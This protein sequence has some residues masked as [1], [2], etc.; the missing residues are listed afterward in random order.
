MEAGRGHPAL[1]ITVDPASKFN[2][3]EK[4]SLAAV[5]EDPPDPPEPAPEGAEPTLE[6]T[7]GAHGPTVCSAIELHAAPGGLLPGEPA[8]DS[9]GTSTAQK[10][11]GISPATSEPAAGI[12]WTMTAGVWVAVSGPDCAA[13]VADVWD[14]GVARKLGV[15]SASLLTAGISGVTTPGASPVTAGMSGGTTPGASG[16]T[17]TAP[18]SP[19]SA[20][21]TCSTTPPTPPA[22][23]TICA[24]GAAS[25]ASIAGRTITGVTFEMVAARTGAIAE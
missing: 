17:G 14:A 15:F 19:G 24:T 6:A 23:A 16:I 3:V 1:D 25:T 8:P 10:P 12:P 2:D 5:P 7:A 21:T 4:F 13:L 20:G 18:G 9:G 22:W 11:P